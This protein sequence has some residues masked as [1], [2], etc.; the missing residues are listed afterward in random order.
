[1]E[2]ILQML[3]PSPIK[4][5]TSLLLVLCL[6]I[7]LVACGGKAPETTAVSPTP[8]AVATATPSSSPVDRPMGLPTKEFADKP[9]ILFIMGDD[10]G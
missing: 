5:L 10:I 1:V 2:L 8:T 9:N 3:N 4:R 7:S 6:S